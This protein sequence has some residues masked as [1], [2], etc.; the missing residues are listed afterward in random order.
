MSSSKALRGGGLQQSLENNNEPPI[1]RVRLDE[2]AVASIQRQHADSETSLEV[3]HMILDYIAFQT[4]ESCLASR[5]LES[6]G[7]PA[8]DLASNL[9]MSDSFLEIF[10]TKYPGFRADDELRFRILLLRFTTLFTQRLTRNPTTLSTE[11]LDRIRDANIARIR[12]WSESTH[13]LPS[14]NLHYFDI[15][16]Q[17]A[18]PDGDIERNRAHVLHQLGVPPE[19]DQDDN[20]HYGMTTTLS[21]LDLLPMFMELSALRNA[22][23]ESDLTEFWMQFAAEFMLQA[24]L[25]QYLVRGASGSDGVDLAFSWGYRSS[26]S[27]GREAEADATTRRRTIAVN[28]MFEDEDLQTEVAGWNDIKLNYLKSLEPTSQ[29]KDIAGGNS[30]PNG[31]TPFTTERLVTHLEAVASHHPVE[32]FEKSM[33]TFLSALAN[34]ISRPILAQLEDGKLEG[35]SESETAEFL[36]SCGADV[37][38]FFREPVGF[39]RAFAET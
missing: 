15:W 9:A 35:M 30:G 8:Q 27:D 24:C 23:S 5:D 21:L 26:S 37:A 6:R 34:S 7:I 18:I 3:D 4:I 29:S 1:K 14:E 16:D 17:L 20:P 22:M 31:H 39:K 12:S 36:S 33:L 19:N 32:V 25:E 28:E 2:D 11:A 10:K 38:A 13:D